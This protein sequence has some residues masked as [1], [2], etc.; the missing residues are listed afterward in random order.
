M[1]WHRG[2][3]N[4]IK[5]YK[6]TLHDTREGS[7]VFKRKVERLSS[8]LGSVQTKL[9]V[10]EADWEVLR[11]ELHTTQAE[12]REALVAKNAA[13]EEKKRA[14][15]E[16]DSVLS[17]RDIERIFWEQ[18]VLDRDWALS[19]QRKRWGHGHEEQGPRI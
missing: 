18:V 14:F 19:F 1:K 16:R 9:A 10:S 2:E 17:G 12:K 15:V 8:E 5:E 6:K 11:A 3:E 7:E 13:L 4:L